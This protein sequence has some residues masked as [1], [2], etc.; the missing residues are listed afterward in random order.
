MRYKNVSVL[1]EN[2]L[3]DIK[4]VPYNCWWKEK[5]C[6]HLPRNC[7]SLALVRCRSERFWNACRVIKTKRKGNHS[8]QPQL[9]KTLRPQ[10][11]IAIGFAFQQWL[12]KWREFCQRSTKRCEAKSS[13]SKLLSK[14]KLLHSNLFFISPPCKLPSHKC[15]LLSSKT[16]T[17]KESFPL[18]LPRLK[19]PPDFPPFLPLFN[20]SHAG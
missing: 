8:N 7:V 5:L 17:Q 13:K 16:L 1:V 9:Q 10:V 6:L 4:E 2:N 19:L 14:W 15:P 11:T 20:T 18:P 3:E 12:T